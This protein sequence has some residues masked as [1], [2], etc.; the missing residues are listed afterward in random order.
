MAKYRLITNKTEDF[1]QLARIAFNLRH[2]TKKYKEYFGAENRKAMVLWEER[3]DSFLGKNVEL[4]AGE[5]DAP[6]I[7][8][9]WSGENTLKTVRIDDGRV[10]GLPDTKSAKF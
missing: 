6:E 2:F 3:M 5:Y 7:P 4:V 10:N 1:E 9:K 8:E